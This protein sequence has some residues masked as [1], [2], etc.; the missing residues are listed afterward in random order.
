MSS[1]EGGTDF[2]GVTA[3]DIDRVAIADLASIKNYR[4]MHAGHLTVYQIHFHGGGQAEVSTEESGR[5]A[6]LSCVGDCR[7]RVEGRTLVLEG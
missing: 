7:H 5:I 6:A 1:L 2:P 3:A 4:L